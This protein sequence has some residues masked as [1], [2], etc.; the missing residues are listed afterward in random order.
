MF[1]HSPKNVGLVEEV[2]VNICGFFYTFLWCG[3]KGGRRGEGGGE[4]GGGREEGG[5]RREEG[6]EEG[7][8]ER[9]TKLSCCKLHVMAIHSPKT[10]PVQL[11]MIAV[12][13]SSPQLSPDPGG[14]GQWRS[15]DTM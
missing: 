11:Q 12:V 9:N 13:S 2:V 7:R 8:E 6:R 4:G 3:W 1:V 10:M 5:G 14:S 15:H